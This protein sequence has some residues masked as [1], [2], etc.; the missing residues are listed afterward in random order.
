MSIESE[1]FKKK[2]INYKKLISYG[3]KKEKNIYKYSKNF[4]DNTF[5]V[6]VEIKD[7]GEVSGK[8]FDLAVDDEYT[9][10][11]IENQEGEFVNKIREEFRSVLSEIANKCCNSNYF[12]S[13]QANRIAN[14]IYEKYNDLPEFPWENDDSGVFRNPVSKKWYGLIMCIDRSRISK[15]T[16]EVE[17]LN[18]KLDEDKIQKLL[19]KKGY[20]TCY[21]MNKKKWITIALDNTLSDDEIMQDIIESHRYTEKSAEWIVPSNPKYYDI[22]SHFENQDVVN[23][24]QSSDV[25]VGDTIY[26]YVGAPYSA[27]LYKCVAEEVNLPY[28]FKDK[29][30][31]IKRVMKLKI[32]ERYDKNKYTFEFLKKHDVRAVRGPRYMPEELSKI[33]NKTKK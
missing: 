4:L 18:V 1:V 29:N 33:I 26:L 31:E 10:F 32:L 12:V 3:F 19:K 28:K 8:V 2:V 16:G 22:I 23:W 20:Y 13:E 14:K 7:N 27:I 30:L 17:V 21:H 5:K 11:R 6:C 24:K 25:Q 9:N 15:E